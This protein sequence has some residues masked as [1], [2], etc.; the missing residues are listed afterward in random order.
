M[1]ILLFYPSWRDVC[2]WLPEFALIR[3]LFRKVS[4]PT[5]EVSSAVVADLHRRR[6]TL[7]PTF[8]RSGRRKDKKTTIKAYQ[9]HSDSTS[10]E[11]VPCL[12]RRTVEPLLCRHSFCGLLML[13]AE[14]GGW[15]R[16]FIDFYR[17]LARA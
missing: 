9:H 16:D 1:E 8:S 6:M 2:K 3:I 10:E 5:W 7:G 12:R 13:V 15:L 17:S 4:Y 14:A 11:S